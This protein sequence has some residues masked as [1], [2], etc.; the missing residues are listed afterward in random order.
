M[1]PT[2]TSRKPC[3]SCSDHCRSSGEESEQHAAAT[4][5]GYA[6]IRAFNCNLR[7][8]LGL[9]LR[10]AGAARDQ[11][12]QVRAVFGSNSFATSGGQQNA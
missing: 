9:T 5:A 10:N 7:A 12:R 3:R 4:G 8:L 1:P 6:L 2:G 11:S